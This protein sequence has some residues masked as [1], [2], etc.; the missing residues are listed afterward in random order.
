MRREKGFTLVELLVVIAII[1]ILIALLLPAVQ[2]A[3]EAARRSQC[4]NN[5]KQVGL[6][7]HNYN[8]VFKVL[9]ACVYRNGQNDFWRGYSAF[10]MILPFMEQEAVYEQVQTDS[11]QFFE[12]WDVGAMS[13]ARRPT[14]ATFQCPSDSPFPAN[15][16]RENNTGCNY[17][18]SFGSTLQWANANAQNGMF[19]AHNEGINNPVQREIKFAEVRD[20]LTNTLMVS[21]HLTGDMNGGSLINGE[22]SEVRSAVGWSGGSTEYPSAADLTT[23]GQQ[24]EQTTSHLSSNGGHWISPQPTQASLNTVAPPNWQ[25][26]NCQVSSSG[27]SSDRNGLYTPRSRHPGGVNAALG[28]ASVRF[29][30][31]TIDLRTFQWIGGRDDGNALPEF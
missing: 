23:W 17:G 5:L 21:E 10:T 28:D 11:R 2:A 20:G 16:G 8:D 1:G 30:S 3:R 14:I 15:T 26:P 9:P 12:H 6:A 7:L 25:F 24:C 4:S 13:T 27:Y 29:I 19:R 18:V 22:T 31:E